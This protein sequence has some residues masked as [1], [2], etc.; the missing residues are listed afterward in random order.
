METVA[1]ATLKEGTVRFATARGDVYEVRIGGD[2][3]PEIRQLAV[4]LNDGDAIRKCDLRGDA[5]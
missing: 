2:G 5:P 3:L 1:Y 4:A